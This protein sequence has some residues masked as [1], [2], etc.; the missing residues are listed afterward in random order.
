MGNLPSNQVYAWTEEDY[1]VSDILQNYAVNF[2]KSKNPNGLGLPDWPAVNEADSPKVIHIRIPAELKD[3][4]HEDRY[5]FLDQL[6]YG[7]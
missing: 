6:Q 3:S 4:Q 1:K 2:I 7:D 5:Q